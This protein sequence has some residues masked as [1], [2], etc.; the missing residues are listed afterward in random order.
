MTLDD[1][2]KRALTTA[3]DN[4]HELMQR[5]LGI[6]GEAGEIAEKLKKWYRDQ[7]ADEAQLDKEGLAGEL[8]DVL[9][10]VATLSEYLGFT[11]EEVANHNLEKL[12]SRAQRG[13]LGGSGDNR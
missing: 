3:I 5:A 9:W 13:Q 4:G 2:Q 7:N 8:G 11:L 12:A 10:Y 6:V 1:Y